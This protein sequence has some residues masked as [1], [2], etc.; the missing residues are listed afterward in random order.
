VV[1]EVI[2]MG[3]T[4]NTSYKIGGKLRLSVALTQNPYPI[5]TS[6]TSGGTWRRSW[7]RRYVTDK[8]LISHLRLKE[9]NQTQN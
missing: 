9:R 6:S 8:Y 1:I 7:W 4:I 3:L 5:D 2:E